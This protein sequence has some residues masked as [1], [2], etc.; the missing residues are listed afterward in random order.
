M[1]IERA[2]IIKATAVASPSTP[3]PQ[4]SN[5]VQ[6]VALARRVPHA[7][8][9]AHAEAERIV[10]DARA[11]ATKLIAEA[12]ANIANNA[13]AAA[14]EAR[15][16]EIARLAAEVLMARSSEEQRA[17]RELDRTVELAVLLAERLI[18]EALILEP[19]R[20][21]ALALEALKETRGARQVRV[22]A[23]PDDVPALKESLATL[24]DGVATIEASSELPR[25]SLV[26][27]TELGR[28]DARLAPQLARLSEALREVLR[29]SPRS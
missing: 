18:G 13:E 28:V 20:V 19:A 24:G 6:S 11:S 8:V 29:P 7:V 15:E 10:N 14:R 16:R 3:S 21:G 17:E 4:R 26:V 25:G 23:C 2:R 12:S 22:E 9:D 27:H 5:L 1:T